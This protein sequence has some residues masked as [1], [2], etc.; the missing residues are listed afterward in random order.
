MSTLAELEAECKSMAADLR[1]NSPRQS[2]L[3]E[4][5]LKRADALKLFH[6]AVV[7]QADQYRR[8]VENGTYARWHASGGNL[9]IMVRE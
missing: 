9:K 8:D 3:N 1:S 4:S 2:H 5:L 7:E 6:D